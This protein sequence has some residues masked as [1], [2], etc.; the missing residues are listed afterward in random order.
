MSARQGLRD[1]LYACLTFLAMGVS[2][3]LWPVLP[4]RSNALAS[5]LANGNT[6]FKLRICYRWFKGLRQRQVTVMIQG[7]KPTM[8]YMA[9]SSVGASGTGPSWR[10]SRMPF[11]DTGSSSVPLA[12]PMSSVIEVESTLVSSGCVRPGF[13]AASTRLSSGVRFRRARLLVAAIIFCWR[14]WRHCVMVSRVRACR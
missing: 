9:A 10:G 6:A 5:F 13:C 12:P 4:L 3:Y 7:S 1:I 14:S 8:V 2:L 11:I